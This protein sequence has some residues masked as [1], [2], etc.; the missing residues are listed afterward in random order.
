MYNNTKWL[1]PPA[2]RQEPRHDDRREPAY[3]PRPRRRDTVDPADRDR[4]HRERDDPRVQYQYVETPANPRPRRR[5][6]E[7]RREP[8]PRYAD[9]G[10]G[11]R[12]RYDIQGGNVQV[13]YGQAAQDQAAY[14]MGNTMGTDYGY[15]YG[16][17]KY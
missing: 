8:Q 4:R 9:D 10:R 12:Q 3:Q 11:G 1:E 17:Y 15:G 6:E 16:N 2:P 7:R 14:Y 13:N 5:D